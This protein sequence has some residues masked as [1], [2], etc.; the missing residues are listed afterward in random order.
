M[1]CWGGLS[2]PGILASYT[3]TI[4]EISPIVND[5]IATNENTRWIQGL[6]FQD[7]SN[8]SI[9]SLDFVPQIVVYPNPINSN[10]NIS[11][12]TKK[13][14]NLIVRTLNNIGQEIYIS[15]EINLCRGQ[16]NLLLRSDEINIYKQGIYYFIFDTG[17][18]RI[19]KKIIMFKYGIDFLTAGKALD[20]LH[21]KILAEVDDEARN[22][23]EKCHSHVM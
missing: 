8:I 9:I 21:G 6:H 20:I 5:F 10:I 17:N 1:P 22:K 18:N 14:T 23:I 2:D 19:V 12:Q 13:A 11:I 15:K 3:T 7:S 16:N 4:F